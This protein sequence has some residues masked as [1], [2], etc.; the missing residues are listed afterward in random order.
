[1]IKRELFVVPK[2]V[3]KPKLRL[4]CFPYA[5]GAVHT[6]TD[7]VGKLGNSVEVVLVQPPGRG[8]RMMETAHD[9]MDDVIAELIQESSFI[10]QVPYVLFGHSL[11]SRIAFELSCALHS[12]GERQ[13]EYFIASGSRAPHLAVDEKKTYMLPESEFIQE[14]EKLNG[15]PKEVLDNVELMQLLTPLLRA[16]FKIAETYRA[17]KMPMPYPILTLHGK[18]DTEITY[19]QLKAWGDLTHM[20]HSIEE[21]SGDH[22]FIN[23]HSQSV[24]QHVSQVIESVKMRI[25]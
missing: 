6:Y 7:W 25:I 24:I 11:G 15:T 8:S 22:F 12:R 10:T 17:T 16:D 5:G 14:L 2:P 21:L 3:L 9:C 19:D 23:T 20:N 1:M 18:D 4:F 13:P